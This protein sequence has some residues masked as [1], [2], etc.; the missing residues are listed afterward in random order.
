MEDNMLRIAEQC[1]ILYFINLQ[2]VRMGNFHSSKKGIGNNG[3]P[4][5]AGQDDTP[6][7]LSSSILLP[8]L[9]DHTQTQDHLGETVDR[10]YL[11]PLCQL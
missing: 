5:P 9:G 4:G 2:S 6:H 10:A 7:K 3:M 11:Y 1:Q 8:L